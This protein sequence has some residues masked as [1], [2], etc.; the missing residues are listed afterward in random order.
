MSPASTW[1]KRRK[2]AREQATVAMATSASQAAIERLEWQLSLLRSDLGR[3][4]RFAD[5]EGAAIT[6]QSGEEVRDN[7][8]KY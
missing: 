1:Y 2:Q 8:I 3:C 5:D 7:R 4:A 6:G